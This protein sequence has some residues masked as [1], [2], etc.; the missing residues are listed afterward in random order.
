[1][2]TKAIVVKSDGHNKH[3]MSGDAAGSKHTTSNTELEFEIEIIPDMSDTMTANNLRFESLRGSFPS[4][5]E[6]MGFC[7]IGASIRGW[8]R[9]PSGDNARFTLGPVTRRC[10]R[11]NHC[12]DWSGLGC[13]CSIRPGQMIHCSARA[14]VAHNF[15]RLREVGI[16]SVKIFMV[17]PNKKEYRVIKD[18]NFMLELDG[19]TNFRKVSVKADGYRLEL[20]V[21]VDTTQTVIA[22]FDEIATALSVDDHVSLP[23]TISNVIGTTQTLEIKSHSYYEYGTFKS[24]TYWQLNPE[25][26]GDDSV[27]SN[28]LDTMA[29]VQPPRLNRLVRAPS[30]ATPSK[31]LE[32]KR[33]KSLV[34]EDSDVEASGDSSR[35]AGKNE[36]DCVSTDDVS[37][38]TPPDGSTDQAGSRSDKKKGLAYV[39]ASSD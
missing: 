22:I 5:W 10:D 2:S 1:M 21:S 3:H 33:T 14:S 28:A 35:Y 12:H 24:F 17:K 8:Q 7:P 9:L 6:S 26:G 39:D 29:D 19:S 36:V 25:E 18:D 34:I 11:H 16:Y 13:Q 15:L 20:D 23:P 4:K 30:V 31:P 27:G 37:G 32:P 38:N